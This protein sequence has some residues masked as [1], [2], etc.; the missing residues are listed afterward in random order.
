MRDCLN[1]ID[2]N[3]WAGLAVHFDA[4]NGIGWVVNRANAC[5]RETAALGT[6][7]SIGEHRCR[8]IRVDLNWHGMRCWRRRRRR[9]CVERLR[10]IEDEFLDGCNLLPVIVLFELE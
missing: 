6:I 3:F 8:S 5:A 7:L 2:D 10:T 1:S 4:F 9:W